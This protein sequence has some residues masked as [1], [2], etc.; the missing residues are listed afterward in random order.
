MSATDDIIKRIDDEAE[1][2]LSWAV[3]HQK[4]RMPAS[5][6]IFQKAA[7][8]LMD[9]SEHMRNLDDKYQTASRN[10]SVYRAVADDLSEELDRAEKYSIG[11]NLMRIGRIIHNYFR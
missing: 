5:Q 6:A 2:M 10:L 1:I 11:Y 9:A 8:T 4:L 7:E 3:R